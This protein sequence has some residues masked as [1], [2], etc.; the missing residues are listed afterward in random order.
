MFDHFDIRTELERQ[1]FRNVGAIYW[2]ATTP[3]LYEEI[4]KRREG[5][6]AHLGPIV[7]RT[8]HLMGRS[9]NDRFIVREPS[10]EDKIWWSPANKEIDE[11]KFTHLFHR[12]QAYFQN[13]D[14]FIQDCYAGAA[15]KY[16]H[17]IR[18]ITEKAWH[19]LFARNMFIQ[20]KRQ[21]EAGNHNPEFTIINVPRFQAI[22]E[23]DGTSSEAFILL[24][25]GKNLV[26]IGG[27][28]YAG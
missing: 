27:T 21:D 4:I 3:R 10:S 2:N 20:M 13:K 17:P 14:L 11:E 24:H 26:L 22:P 23:L 19:S 28:S 7:V 12:L 25:L 9:P 6:I 5:N 18:V 8:G 16:K 15:R 1:G